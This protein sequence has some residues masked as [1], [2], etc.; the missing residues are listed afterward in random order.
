MEFE[1]ELDQE[2]AFKILKAIEDLDQGEGALEEDV[3]ALVWL[4]HEMKIIQLLRQ[5]LIEHKIRAS[6]P[7]GEEEPSF[8]KVEE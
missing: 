4:Q 3:R 1:S 7:D 5:L 6:W 2:R 8:T